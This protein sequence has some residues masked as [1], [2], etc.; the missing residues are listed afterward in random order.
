MKLDNI[1]IY[2]TAEVLK[3]ALE[4]ETKKQTADSKRLRN[5]LRK[6][7]IEELEKENEGEVL[8][9]LSSDSDIEIVESVA[10][11]TRARKVG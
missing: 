7:P 8:E 1:I 9:I 2:N 6:R 11:R 10:R 5:R 3:V 4:K